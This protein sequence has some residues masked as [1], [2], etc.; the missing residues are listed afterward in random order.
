MS[1]LRRVKIPEQAKKYPGQLSGGQQQRVATARALVTRPD[2]IFADEPTG[3]LD[4]RSATE[5]LNQIRR[6]VDE[7]QQTVVMVTHD[8]RAA[9]YADRVLFLADGRVVSD[10]RSPT[11]DRI[12]DT[13]RELTEPR[14]SEGLTQRLNVRRRYITRL[15]A[16]ARAQVVGEVREFVVAER[17]GESRHRLHALRSCE[18]GGV[19]TR[20]IG[21]VDIARRSLCVRYWLLSTTTGCI[22]PNAEPWRLIP[23]AKN[24]CRSA[25]FQPRAASPAGVICGGTTRPRVEPCS[26]FAPFICP[27]APRGVWHSSQ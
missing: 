16:S 11:A 22:S 4:S 15:A 24:V 26:A 10:M 18:L 8:A 6:A 20:P 13:I 19:D 2:L 17:G 1:Y 21:S 7:Y 5:L 12:L 27:N 14:D 9:A 23:V 25:P 3:S